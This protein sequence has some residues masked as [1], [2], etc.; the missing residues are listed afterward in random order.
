MD[1]APRLRDQ[2]ALARLKLG[3]VPER[4]PEGLV[5][6][7]P[8]DIEAVALK[9]GRNLPARRLVVDA[10]CDPPELFEVPAQRRW[11]GLPGDHLAEEFALH[12]A[13]QAHIA[14]PLRA[15]ERQGDVGTAVCSEQGLGYVEPRLPQRC[16]PDQLRV[17]LVE[18]MVPGPVDTQYVGLSSLVDP[19][20]GVLAEADRVRSGHRPDPIRRVPAP[21]VCAVH[22]RP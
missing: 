17:Q 14:P 7:Q 5:S 4:S 9:S 20:A 12:P 13:E 3:Q 21:R 10:G 2:L 18:R 15:R 11:V 16:G 8:I 1:D 22:C 19:K 6:H